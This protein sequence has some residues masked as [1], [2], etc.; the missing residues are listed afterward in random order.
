MATVTQQILKELAQ[1]GKPYRTKDE[2]VTRLDINPNGARGRLSR[3][4]REGL[5]T[6]SDRGYRVTWAGILH[7]RSS[8]A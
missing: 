4:V 5:V 2:L 8:G 6:Q 7:L 3:M 1:R